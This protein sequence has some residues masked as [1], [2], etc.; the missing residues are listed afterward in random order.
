MSRGDPLLFDRIAAGLSGVAAALSDVCVAEVEALE[1]T[2]LQPRPGG[3]VP[4]SRL[5][6][7]GTPLQICVVAGPDGTTVRLIGDPGAQ[8]G[9]APERLALMRQALV[10]LLDANGVA[11]TA[12][13]LAGI[14]PP[15]AE[16]RIDARQGVLW[17]G[18][19]LP[20]TGRAVYAKASWDGAAEDWRRC[21]ALAQALLPHPAGAE[22]TI[23]ALGDSTYPVS[24]GLEWGGVGA[25]A[26]RFKLYWRLRRPVPLAEL[27]APLI[28]DPV[29]AAFLR[30]VIGDRR[31]ARTGLVFSTGFSLAT[32]DL[33]DT[34]A[35]VCAHCLPRPAAE[36]LP[37]IEQV[38][39]QHGLASPDIAAPL[40]G[41]RA[42]LAFLGLG[43][44]AAR[45]KR[46]NVYLKAPER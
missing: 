2:L 10:A 30:T 20:G 24:V 38:A 14:L 39:T 17:L 32:G 16:T 41:G 19:S 27:G 25:N 36:W 28:G 43:L 44:T 42:E 12:Q 35:D 37:L 21:R 26:G 40:G 6:N 9:S 18:A 5:N 33:T 29:I 1:A 15:T 8:A 13:I 22:A 3:A 46:L 31:V 45:D 23:E 4:R 7:D 11:L 34:K